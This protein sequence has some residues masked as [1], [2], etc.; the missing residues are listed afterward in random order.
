MYMFIYVC[1]YMRMCMYLC[2]TYTY[3]HFFPILKEKKTFYTTY[4]S[5]T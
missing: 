1:M 3:I 2:N 4:F 5:L